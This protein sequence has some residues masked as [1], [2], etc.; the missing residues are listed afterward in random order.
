MRRS[1]YAQ[2]RPSLDFPRH[3]VSSR[4]LMGS[5]DLAHLLLSKNPEN[6]PISNK[7]VNEYAEKILSGE[8]KDEGKG[9]QP[10]I[11]INDGT[12]I[13][14]QHRLCAIIKANKAVKMRVWLMEK[15]NPQT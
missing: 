5:P 15:T 7:L 3:L 13:N 1:F 11:V 12:L 2:K 14:G 10:L 8:W 6:R 9:F 4:M